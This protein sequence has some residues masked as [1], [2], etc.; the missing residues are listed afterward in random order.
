M[1]TARTIVS[2]PD[3]HTAVLPKRNYLNAEHGIMS[4]LLT[5]DHKRIA[6]LYLI[7]ITLMFFIGG[8]MAGMIRLESLTPQ[9][10]LV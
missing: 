10:D 5:Q 9:S 4:W 8:A 3:Q 7:S 1:A 6:I 2:L